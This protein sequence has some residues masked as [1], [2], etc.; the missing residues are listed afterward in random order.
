M[1]RPTLWLGI[2]AMLALAACGGGT[3]STVK[4]AP[5][6]TTAAPTPT[7]TDLTRVVGSCRILPKTSCAGASL[8]GADLHQADLSDADLQRVDLGGANLSGANLRGADLTSAVITNANLSHADLANTKLHNVNLTGSVLAGATFRGAST[9]NHNLFAATY[10]CHTTI[11][12]GSKPPPPP[13]TAPPTPVPP[14]SGPPPTPPTTPPTTTPAPP[15]C[16]LTVLEAAYT[17]KFGPAPDGTTFAI[18]ACVG[19]YAGTNLA[20]PDIGSAF[21]VYQTQGSTWVALSVGTEGVCDGLGIPPD[22]QHE[23]RCV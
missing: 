19:G 17:A 4:P 21:A 15:P 18:T 6:S 16:T 12:N 22:V 2:V 13:P 5:T 20:N 9:N 23:I 14:T 3:S 11:P 7:S 8:R 1:H 10:R